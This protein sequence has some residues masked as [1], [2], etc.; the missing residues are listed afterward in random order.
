[1]LTWCI[2]IIAIPLGPSLPFPSLL[3]ILNAVTI[4]ARTGT[5]FLGYM[6]QARSIPGNMLI[7]SFTAGQNQQ[8]LNCDIVG[9]AT[10]VSN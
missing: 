10:M 3:Y 1:M 8:T 5:T 6:I 4:N 7:G 9:V 2:Y